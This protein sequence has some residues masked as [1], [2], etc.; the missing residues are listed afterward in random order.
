M[1]CSLPPPPS[2]AAAQAGVGE[3][4]S[5]P[6]SPAEKVANAKAAAVI[7]DS[8][9]ASASPKLERAQVTVG[10][11]NV[12]RALGKASAHAEYTITTVTDGAPTATVVKR[13]SDFDALWTELRRWLH[14][15]ELPVLPKKGLPFL[16]FGQLEKPFLEERRAGLEQAI[17]KL[18]A[19]GDR[20]LMQH[21][22]GALLEAFLGLRS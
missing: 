8:Y 16:A 9:K 11:V 4:G 15:S 19:R 3:D 7:K 18:I 6:T 2:P 14:W 13:Y 21:G 5:A 1:H 20:T 22:P 17:S 12:V 10:P